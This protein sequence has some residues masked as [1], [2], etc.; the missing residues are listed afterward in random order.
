MKKIISFAKRN[1]LTIIGA[2]ALVVGA[3]GSSVCTWFM[4]DQPECPKEL[5]K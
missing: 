3:A 1:S 5:L 4:S 2:L